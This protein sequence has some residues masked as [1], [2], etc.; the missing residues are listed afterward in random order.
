MQMSL[1]RHGLNW[2]TFS[3]AAVQTGFGPFVSVYLTQ[4]GWPQTEIGLALNEIF[5]EF[6]SRNDRWMEALSRGEAVGPN[7]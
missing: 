4:I 2:L 1:T 6:G 3:T 5:D 7:G